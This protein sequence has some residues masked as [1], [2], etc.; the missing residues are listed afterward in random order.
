MKLMDH[1]NHAF[2]EHVPAANGVFNFFEELNA[3]G[4]IDPKF[5]EE[6]SEQLS[7]I[8]EQM[9]NQ[10][11][12]DVQPDEAAKIL[13]KVFGD[14]VRKKHLANI[15]DFGERKDGTKRNPD[16]RDLT[17]KEK[18]EYKTLQAQSVK[19]K[20]NRS[21]LPLLSLTVDEM[22]KIGTK[23]EETTYENF[24]LDMQ[25]L[26]NLVTSKPTDIF[27]QNEKMAKSTE[28][29]GNDYVYETGIPAFKGLLYNQAKGKF[30]VVKTC[31]MAGQCFIWC[32]A[33][34]GYYSMGSKPMKLTQRLNLLINNNAEYI[35]MAVDELK[36]LVKKHDAFT[37]NKE[38]NRVVIRWNDAGDFFNEHESIY[39]KTA[40]KII[41]EMEQPI[42]GKIPAMLHYAYTKNSS[43]LISEKIHWTYSQGGT[44][45]E[46]VVDVKKNKSSQAV[47][48]VEKNPKE[49]TVSPSF[50]K[51]LFVRVQKGDESTLEF[52]D[53]KSGPKT[54]MKRI[55]DKYGVNAG[56]GKTNRFN[57]AMPGQKVKGASEL[58]MQENLP[59]TLGE[60][61]Q[62]A[63]VVRP[64]GDTDIGAMR[65]DVKTIFL[66][67]H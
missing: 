2:Y 17:P 53:P 5:Y 59:R 25:K 16:A 14:V 26:T 22:K 64:S 24:K 29:F 67:M 61:G 3:Y 51:D 52:K 44:E 63:V 32:Y 27:S 56:D 10:G 60:K 62:Y 8:F 20:R 54:L 35:K 41:E 19:D 30:E 31:P 65:T 40:E 11:L 38:K 46:D 18:E 28:K 47:P 50:F 55:Y 34:K 57:I 48:D 58:I 37:D 12:T 13:S 4:D 1:I 23:G 39:L 15:K 43:H 9:E 7:L 45:K 21:S 36:T 42:D 6:F 66:L 33:R 49:K